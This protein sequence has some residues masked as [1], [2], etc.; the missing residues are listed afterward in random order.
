M[1][2]LDFFKTIGVGLF[3]PGALLAIADEKKIITPEEFDEILL[4]NG[5]DLVIPRNEWGGID[6]PFISFTRFKNIEIRDVQASYM[7]RDST[8]SDSYPLVFP[9]G[10]GVELNLSLWADG[11]AYKKEQKNFTANRKRPWVDERKSSAVGTSCAAKIKA[12][13]QY[14]RIRITYE[15]R[16]VNSW[17]VLNWVRIGFVFS[18]LEGAK[19][20]AYLF[21]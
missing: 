21:R 14:R 4:E 3:V 11:N 7:L 20:G 19:I 1:K 13:A 15:L 12:V 10:K 9:E 18:G 8:A 2:R 5:V 17:L 6:N 16:G